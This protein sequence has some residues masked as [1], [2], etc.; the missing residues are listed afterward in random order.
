MKVSSIR[1]LRGPN[2]W[3]R[4][5]AI[6]A[7]VSCGETGSLVETRGFM[8]RL[9]DRF[10]QIDLL[11]PAFQPE[12]GIM[13]HALGRAALGLQTQ[14]GC[15][16]IFSKTTRTLE[17]GVYQVIVE[18]SEESVGRLAI[19]FALTLCRAAIEDT[20]FDI[21]DAVGRLHER[22][23]EIRFGPSTGAIVRAA[24]AR[25]IPFRRLTDGSMVQFGWGSRQRRIQAAET[26]RTS[27]VAES[28]AQDKEL[29]RTLL[30]NAGIP[31]AAGRPVASA[32]DAWIAAC[33]IGG[34]VVVKPRD[35][36]QGRGV[37]VNLTSREQV[38]A[39]YAVAAEISDEVLVERCVPGND[40]RMLVV[41]N[42][43]IA[44]ARRDPPQ[45]VGDGMHSISQLVE[46]INSDPRR[47]EGHANALTKI[48]F[49]EITVAQ[50]ATKGLAPESVPSR[51]ERVVLRNNANLST[52][53]QPPMS[54]MTFIPSLPRAW[55]P[56][57][58]W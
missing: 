32:E 49:D 45:V 21:A 57:P 30:S 40:Y 41:G 28:I 4:H 29:T 37:G 25:D 11:Q 22:Y 36:N 9:R 42:K 15:P 33:E 55:K 13:A 19:E 44:A 14:A 43:L 8:T 58:E 52:G 16:V 39:A 23:E 7:I 50:L 31:I 34:P 51:G 3:S 48:Y 56:L 35:G 1:A 17:A 2:L 18:Y 27:L 10:P 6:E 47:G 12:A 54:P 24:V 26:G 46:Q 5:T 38:D 53:E 20:F